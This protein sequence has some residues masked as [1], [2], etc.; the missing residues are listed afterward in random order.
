MIILTA[1]AVIGMVFLTMESFAA[2]P[3]AYGFSSTSVAV[4][5]TL[6]IAMMSRI[7]LLIMLLIIVWM[8]IIVIHIIAINGIKVW[9]MLAPDAVAATIQVHHC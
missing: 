1:T 7:M 3:M 6:V 5:D 8:F 2:A 9:I 4:A